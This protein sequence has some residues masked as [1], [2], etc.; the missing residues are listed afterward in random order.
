MRMNIDRLYETL[1]CAQRLRAREELIGREYFAQHALEQREHTLSALAAFCPEPIDRFLKSIL[2]PRRRLQ[3]E[4]I[5]KTII[6]CLR[7][8]KFCEWYRRPAIRID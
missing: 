5:G 6:E 1:R 7:G 8:K 3:I 4:M 2:K